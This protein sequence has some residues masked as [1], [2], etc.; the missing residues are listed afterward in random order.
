MTFID[1]KSCIDV[2]FLLSDW[3]QSDK[4]ALLPQVEMTPNIVYANSNYSMK[5]YILAIKSQT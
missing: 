5:N 4:K 1:F 3:Y 2:Y